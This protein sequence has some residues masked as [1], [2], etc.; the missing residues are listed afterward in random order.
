MHGGVE[1]EKSRFFFKDV[2]VKIIEIE[3]LTSFTNFL[4]PPTVLGITL[5]DPTTPTVGR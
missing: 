1:F 3:I 2:P 5:V 4:K